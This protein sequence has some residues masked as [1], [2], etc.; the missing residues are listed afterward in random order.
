MSGWTRPARLLAAPQSRPPTTAQASAAAASPRMACTAQ[1]APVLLDRYLVR[2]TRPLTRRC[3]HSCLRACRYVAPEVLCSA[4]GYD[5]KPVDIWSAG[6][7]LYVMLSGVHQL[8]PTGPTLIC[9]DGW[10][11]SARTVRHWPGLPQG[12][13]KGRACS[14]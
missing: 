8:L 12:C 4:D 2:W 9:T 3:S 1:L 11:R 5:G 7:V 14:A 10:S 6:V 13:G